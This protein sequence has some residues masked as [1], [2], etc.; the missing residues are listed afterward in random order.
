VRILSILLAATPFLPA[1]DADLLP[2]IREKMGDVL[3][4]QP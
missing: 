3:L 1:Q 4:R 2:R